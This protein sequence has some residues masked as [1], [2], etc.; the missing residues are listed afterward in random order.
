M[1]L[2][3]FILPNGIRL[4]H[5]PS[6]STVSYFSWMINTG[7]RDEKTNEHGLAHF[8]EH[9]IFKGT[10]K[11]NATQIINRLETVGGDINAYTTKEE[12]CIYATFLTEYY[13]RTMELISDMVFHSSFPE[14]EIKKERDIII[15]EINSYLDSPS[16]MIFDDFEDIIFH[17]HALG[18]SILGTPE[19]LENYTRDDLLQFI[20]KN[21]GT[22]RMVIGSIGN[23][24]FEKLVSYVKKYFGQQSLR[25]TTHQRQQFL[26]YRASTHISKKDTHQ[27]HCMIGSIS[28]KLSNGQK[29][30]MGLLNNI[31]GSTNMNSRLSM[32]LREKHGFAYDVESNF[33][34]YSDAGLMNIYVGT[35]RKN[36]AASIQLVHNELKKLREKKLSPTQLR[37]AKKQLIGQVAIGAENKESLLLA[38][39]KGFMIENKFDDLSILFKKVEK[40]SAEDLQEMAQQIF[41]EKKISILTYQ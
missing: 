5:L 33:G 16:E 28:D 11:R 35:D 17:N 40:I 18:K 19:Q 12:T 14:K 39:T 37:N 8:V 24:S 34:N 15:D 31:L 10:S 36:L 20:N 25:S 2:Q 41:D 38:M 30:T 22:D 6:E 27:A 21:Y 3:T 7:S 32:S 9:S 23:I 26:D 4:V 13:E 1:N 29:M